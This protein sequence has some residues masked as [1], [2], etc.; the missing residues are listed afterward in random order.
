MVY[1]IHI[2]HPA[3][4]SYE[5]W[6]SPCAIEAWHIFKTFNKAGYSVQMLERGMLLASI[7]W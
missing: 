6:K 4:G 7:R 5:I 2:N 1:A 3:T